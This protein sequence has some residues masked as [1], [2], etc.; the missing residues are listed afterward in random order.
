[1]TIFIYPYNW[2]VTA[3]RKHIITED[4]LTGGY[5]CICVEE[6][7][8]NG[9]VVAGLQ[10]IEPCFGVVVVTTVSKGVDVCDMGCVV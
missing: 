1:M 10:I 8:N 3:I 5:E 6:P 2:V 4:A 9:V 7:T